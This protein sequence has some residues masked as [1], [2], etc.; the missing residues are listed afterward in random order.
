MNT[1]IIR[2]HKRKNFRGSSINREI[3]IDEKFSLVPIYLSELN[4]V[5]AF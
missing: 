2:K 1:V 3:A 4:Q 5:H